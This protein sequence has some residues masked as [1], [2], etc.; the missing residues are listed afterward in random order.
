MSDGKTFATCLQFRSKLNGRAWQNDC[1]F[2]QE[3]KLIGMKIILSEYECYKKC[4]L[5]DKTL[6]HLLKTGFKYISTE[7]EN[8]TAWHYYKN[9]GIRLNY[10]TWGRYASYKKNTGY[11][12]YISQ[13]S[14]LAIF[15]Y[16]LRDLLISHSIESP[17]L[18]CA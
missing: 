15:P 12:S 9:A 3:D 18:T 5:L 16:S 4:T 1:F 14:C 6:D 8:T 13:P 17:R 10:S 11:D 7:K 2:F